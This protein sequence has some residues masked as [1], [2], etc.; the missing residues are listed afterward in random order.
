MIGEG[1]SAALIMY[2]VDVVV[3]QAQPAQETDTII[4]F[5]PGAYFDTAT[6]TSVSERI[7]RAPSRPFTATDR[8]TIPAVTSAPAFRLSTIQ[9]TTNQPQRTSTPYSASYAGLPSM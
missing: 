4:W 6:R 2:D 3:P 8:E 9:P 1:G 5:A 7:S